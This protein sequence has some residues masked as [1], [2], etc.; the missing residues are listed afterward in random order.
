MFQVKGTD[1]GF[2]PFVSSV[3]D[4]SGVGLHV[5]KVVCSYSMAE[6]LDIRRQFSCSVSEVGLRF[7]VRL[8]SNIIYVEV[9]VSPNSRWKLF[10]ISARLISVDLEFVLN[11]TSTLW[12]E[13]FPSSSVAE[14][15]MYEATQSALVYEPAAVVCFTFTTLPCR[16][17]WAVFFF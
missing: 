11:S 13:R 17:T 14:S 12:K 3:S 10:L 9:H 2:F 1:S 7:A 8:G 6:N 15:L 5:P 4:A 16:W